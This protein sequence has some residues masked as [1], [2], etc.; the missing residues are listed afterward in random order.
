MSDLSL[1]V[2]QVEDEQ[3]SPVVLFKFSPEMSP[4]NVAH[5]TEKNIFEVYTIIISSASELF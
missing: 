4:G 3:S 2:Q 1:C 5:I